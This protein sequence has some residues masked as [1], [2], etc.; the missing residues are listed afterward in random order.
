MTEYTTILKLKGQPKMRMISIILLSITIS[1]CAVVDKCNRGVLPTSGQY[2]NV[3]EK[4]AQDY[5]EQQRFCEKR[6]QGDNV[7]Y[8]EYDENGKCVLGGLK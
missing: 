7:I 2:K 3:E 4:I 6:F 5:I 1:G 8:Y